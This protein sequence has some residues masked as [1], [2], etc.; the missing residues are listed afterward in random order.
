[1]RSDR[2]L[3]VDTCLWVWHSTNIGDCP[4]RRFHM[5]IWCIASNV[6]SFVEKHKND[7]VPNGDGIH[8]IFIDYAEIE[9]RNGDVPAFY[10]K[11]EK[12]ELPDAFWMWITNTESNLVENLLLASGVR[13]VVNI[14]E[15]DVCRSK[16]ATY[17]RL[18]R[19]GL[20]VPKTWVF[21]NHPDKS[22]IKS[23]FPYPF[24][25]KPDRGFGGEGVALIKNDEELDEYLK[26]IRY[27][28]A[29]MVQEYISA[30]RGKD[31]RVVMLNGECYVSIVR[32]AGNPE[33]FRSNIHQGGSAEKFEPDEDTIKMCKKAASL[34]DLKF[35]GLDLM[36]GDNGFVF[37]EVN[38]FPG[39][40]DRRL[41]EVIDVVTGDMK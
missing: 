34:F 31:L 20:P 15:Q 38:S 23:H 25:I 41:K 2:D 30:S 22:S 37:A 19:A 26:G 32:K 12:A 13:S 40:D 36:F 10:I 29:Y 35:L 3:L 1:M 21:F 27:G 14:A 17:D 7:P 24:V 6:D 16:V 11:G 28:T 33:E 18:A 39:L 9:I 8:L 4:R 5:N